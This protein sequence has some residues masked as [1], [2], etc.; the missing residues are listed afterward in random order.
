MFFNTQ[1]LG[2]RRLDQVC[3][4]VLG[5]IH[6]IW[7]PIPGRMKDY[8]ATPKP[9][10]YRSLHTVV[11]PLGAQGEV[12]IFP[13]GLLIR[14][15]GMHRVSQLGIVAPH[16]DL[17]DLNQVRLQSSCRFSEASNVRHLPH[18]SVFIRALAE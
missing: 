15:A 13:L 7:P 17:G 16:A 9:N 2:C 18:C 4:H 1:R 3:Y 10:G 6:N 14:T 8:I 11:L 5:L 12:D